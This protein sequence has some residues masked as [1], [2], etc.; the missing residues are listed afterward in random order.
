MKFT[1]TQ[2]IGLQMGCEKNIFKYYTFSINTIRIH[3]I[4][5]FILDGRTIANLT[6]PF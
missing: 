1:Q 6:I 3:I 2:D 5:P 4:F